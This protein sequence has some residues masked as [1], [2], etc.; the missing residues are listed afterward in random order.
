MY[1]AIIPVLWEKNRKG[2]STITGIL[3][4]DVQASLKS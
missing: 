1:S 3:F 4:I 2:F